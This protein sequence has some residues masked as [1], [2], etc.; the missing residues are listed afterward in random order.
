MP[1]DLRDDGHELQGLAHARL[2]REQP[3][4]PA[5]SAEKPLDA[6]GLMG[7]QQLRTV[8]ERARVI[9]LREGTREGMRLETAGGGQRVCTCTSAGHMRARCAP[10]TSADPEE[11]A[12]AEASAAPRAAD[13]E[14]ATSSASDPPPDAAARSSRSLVESASPSGERPQSA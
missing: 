13:P 14:A 12:S 11:E 10:S 3:T 4:A 5:D 2:V 1:R 9:E 8:H 6:I 7:H